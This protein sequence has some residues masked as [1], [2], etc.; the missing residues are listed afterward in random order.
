MDGKGLKLEHQDADSSDGKR[1]FPATLCDPVDAIEVSLNQS[2]GMKEL[3][4][5]AGH[6]TLG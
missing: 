1:E 6:H 2:R 3:K 5:T 4:V